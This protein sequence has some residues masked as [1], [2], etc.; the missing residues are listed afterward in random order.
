MVNKFLWLIA[1][2]L[3]P[4]AIKSNFFEEL[5]AEFHKTTLALHARN[6]D[7]Y[8]TRI[9][10][11]AEQLQTFCPEDQGEIIVAY[12]HNLVEKYELDEDFSFQESENF[13]NHI[14]SFIEKAELALPD[15]TTMNREEF[16]LQSFGIVEQDIATL[17]DE[18]RYTPAKF[19][20]LLSL[21]LF[22]QITHTL[23]NYSE[24]QDIL[25]KKGLY[26]DLYVR[27]ILDLCRLQEVLHCGNLQMLYYTC[28]SARWYA[29]LNFQFEMLKALSTG[30]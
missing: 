11:I 5:N 7:E 10:S 27:A 26:Q 21:S 13:T 14:L 6:M 15:A 28:V 30:K 4:F 29:G 25:H 20:K 3:V 9:A 23:T 12:M 16:A 2:T 24:L 19:S 1:S 8:Y 22:E 17:I 18:N